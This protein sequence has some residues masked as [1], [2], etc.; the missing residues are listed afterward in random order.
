M[1]DEV[2]NANGQFV[3]EWEALIAMVNEL[4]AHQALPIRL[5]IAKTGLA[6]AHRDRKLSN[7]IKEQ[8]EEALAHVKYVAFDLEATRREKA[9][10]QRRLANSE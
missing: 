3:T 1:N 6:L 2:K 4:P 7:Q 8:A 10:L 5:Q 9:E